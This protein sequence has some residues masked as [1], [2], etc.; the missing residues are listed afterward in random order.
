MPL[1]LITYKMTYFL[2]LKH[3]MKTSNGLLN[4][5]WMWKMSSSYTTFILAIFLFDL[6][7]QELCY[8][9]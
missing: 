4:N 6:Q 8:Y 2:A 9:H 5:P 1:L 7:T 3:S